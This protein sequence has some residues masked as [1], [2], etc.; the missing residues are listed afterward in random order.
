MQVAALFLHA[1]D[2]R[3]C[4]GWVLSGSNWTP[5]LAERAETIMSQFVKAEE[6]PGFNFWSLIT[7]GKDWVIASR[8]TW[9]M[10][11]IGG[12]WEKLQDDLEN[13]YNR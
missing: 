9:D 12:S 5:E 7:D 1:M 11:S 10:S 3:P 6:F 4:P 8:F 2:S 13:Y